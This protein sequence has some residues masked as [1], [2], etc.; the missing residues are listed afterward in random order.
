MIIFIIF[1]EA[2]LT[3]LLNILHVFYIIQVFE[4]KYLDGLIDFLL[5]LCD[6]EVI[7]SL[8]ILFL[9]I[10]YFVQDIDPNIKQNQMQFFINF[11]IKHYLFSKF[12]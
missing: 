2:C 5:L 6:F 3:I 10:I 9:I 7:V 4:R 8:D 1:L 12:C 11:Y